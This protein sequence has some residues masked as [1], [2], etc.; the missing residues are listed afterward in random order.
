ML[1]RLNSW[2]VHNIAQHLGYD[3]WIGLKVVIPPIPNY[4]TSK[5][6]TNFA[7]FEAHFTCSWEKPRMVTFILIEE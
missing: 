5:D 2:V 6:M 7:K 3:V 1:L 4:P